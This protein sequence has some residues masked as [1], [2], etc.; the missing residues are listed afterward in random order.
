MSAAVL[1]WG[2]LLTFISPVVTLCTGETP[3]Y[4]LTDTLCRIS[5]KRKSFVKLRVPVGMCLFV[6]VTACGTS[7]TH[8]EGNL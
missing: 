8:A 2:T 6:N 7:V 3:H 1:Q 4:S 5:P